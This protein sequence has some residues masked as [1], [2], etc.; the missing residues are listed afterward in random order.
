M[1]IPPLNF[2]ILSVCMGV[3]LGVL[4][5]AVSLVSCFVMMLGCVVG[6]A[7]DADMQYIHMSLSV[8][9]G[10]LLLVCCCLGVDIDILA[11]ICEWLTELKW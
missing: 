10:L 11:V 4:D 2:P 9:F 6:Y 7:V 3:Q 8:S 1:S 5:V